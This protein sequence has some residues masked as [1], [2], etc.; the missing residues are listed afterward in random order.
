M[1]ELIIVGAGGFIGSALRYLVGGWVHRVLDSNSFPYGT[2]TV[3]VLG[4]LAIG[5]LAGQAELRGGIPPEIRLFLF[6]GILGGF[7]TFSA[8]G[9]ETVHMLRNGLLGQAILYIGLQT[10]VGLSAVWGGFHFAKTF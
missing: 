7:T 4:C 9:H 8:F 6:V 3:N 5:W 2:L 10:V 1:R